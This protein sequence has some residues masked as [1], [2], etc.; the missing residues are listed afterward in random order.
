MSPLAQLTDFDHEGGVDSEV[1]DD[2]AGS[3][4][5]LNEGQHC[6]GRE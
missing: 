4:E 3:P 1:M 2:H 5:R 6:A